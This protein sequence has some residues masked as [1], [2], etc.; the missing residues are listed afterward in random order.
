MG[1]PVQEDVAMSRGRKSGWW[2]LALPALVCIPCLLL[3]VLVALAA[4]AVSVAG[5]LLGGVLIA[6]VIL[7]AGGIAS[8]SIYLVLRHRGRREAACCPPAAATRPA[9]GPDEPVKEVAR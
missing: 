5:G 9:T 7:L 8:G 3:P 2:F 4:T 1:T 6:G